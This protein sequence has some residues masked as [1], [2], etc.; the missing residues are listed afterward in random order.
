MISCEGSMARGKANDGVP[1]DLIPQQRRKASGWVPE[2]QVRIPRQEVRHA[3][4]GNP[5][6][7]L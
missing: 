2:D 4:G 7:L 1:D 6:K 5:G 3:C